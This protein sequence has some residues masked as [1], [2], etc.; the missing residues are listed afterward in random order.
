MKSNDFQVNEAARSSMDLL[1]NVPWARMGKKVSGHIRS[2]IDKV[3]NPSKYTGQQADSAQQKYFIDSFIQQFKRERQTH[4]N[5]SVDDFMEM[6]WR[7]N[8]WDASNLPTA[9]KQ[10]LDNAQQAATAN[11]TPQT[12]QQLGNIVYSL[13]LMMP[14]AG[15]ANTQQTR[16]TVQQ[17]QQPQ[18]N[19]QQQNINPAAG[20][21]QLDPNT[22]QII[23]KIRSIKNTPEE[24]DDL[25]DIIAISLFKLYKIAP[26]NYKR[27][28]MSLFNNGGKPSMPAAN[29]IA[30]QTKAPASQQTT[31]VTPSASAAA[32]TQTT[33]NYSSVKGY[34]PNTVSYNNNIKA[35][36]PSPTQSAT[37][38]TS[39]TVPSNRP[40]PTGNRN[41]EFTGRGLGRIDPVNT[42]A[43]DKIS[44]N[45]LDKRINA[46][47]AAQA[48]MTTRAGLPK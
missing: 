30:P 47:S 46:R 20:D 22:N 38:N 44:Q 40:T 42:A 18:Q 2:G 15:S 21:G 1:Q 12:I 32:P 10:S 24:I 7:K 9:Y 39:T 33:P 43:A 41:V 6:Y 48:A 17:P 31:P 11:T 25:V 19:T 13:A 37:S 35:T 36:T 5:I 45:A 16:Q 8:N 26:K 28:V 4:P 27:I 29:N 14:G 34:A 3:M 23:T